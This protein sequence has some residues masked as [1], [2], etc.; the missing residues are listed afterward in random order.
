MEVKVSSSTFKGDDST[1]NVN[2][3]DEDNNPNPPTKRQRTKAISSAA[4]TTNGKN[5]MNDKTVSMRRI[6][7]TETKILKLADAINE[8]I[9]E[10]KI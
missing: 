1:S 4:A 7:S 5:E 3:D 8:I 9:E 6:G 10:N 2:D